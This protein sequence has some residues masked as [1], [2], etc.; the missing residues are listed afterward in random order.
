MSMM[1]VLNLMREG[2]T[3]DDE[4]K[5]LLS[6]VSNERW[7]QLELTRKASVDERQAN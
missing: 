6:F 5:G 4:G 2:L 3:L 1:M 7:R